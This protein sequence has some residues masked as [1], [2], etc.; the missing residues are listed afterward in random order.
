VHSGEGSLEDSDRFEGA[1]EDLPDDV[2]ALLYLDI[3][4]L[5][6]LAEAAGL[7]EDP[8]YALFSREFGTLEGLGVAVEGGDDEI[9]TEIRLT[10]AE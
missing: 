2:S 7:G 8:A 4:G 3:G 5:L 1:T 10:I 6:R 9:D